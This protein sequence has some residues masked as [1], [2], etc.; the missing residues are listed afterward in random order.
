M[1]KHGQSALMAVNLIKNNAVSDAV[2]AWKQ[3]SIN[4]FGKG[5]LHHK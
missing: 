1:N 3:A 4:I 2:E 5:K